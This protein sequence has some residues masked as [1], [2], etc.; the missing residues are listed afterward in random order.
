MQDPE[1]PLHANMHSSQCSGSGSGN[2]GS[3]TGTGCGSSSAGGPGSTAGMC[4]QG[5]PWCGAEDPIS[6]RQPRDEVLAE[7][8]GWTEE[9]L[10]CSDTG[11][12]AQQED[13]AHGEPQPGQAQQEQAQQEQAQQEQA[14]QEQAQQEQDKHTQKQKHGHK[15]HQ[16]PKPEQHRRH[17]HDE[18]VSV[19]SSGAFIWCIYRVHSYGASIRCIY[20]VQTL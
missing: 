13:G 16:E 7:G 5:C 11:P 10:P 4:D 12:A 17:G 15:Q 2:I 1:Q 14:Q 6:L 19:H 8:A 18:H 20:P 3:G 9:G